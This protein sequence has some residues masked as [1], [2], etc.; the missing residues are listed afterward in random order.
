MEI[1]GVLMK[2]RA[3]VEK[4]TAEIAALE[5]EEI[6]DME[7]YLESKKLRLDMDI[8][9]MY[10]IRDEEDVDCEW[11]KIHPYYEW[12]E[13]PIGKWV[14]APPLPAPKKAVVEEQPLPPPKTPERN[15]A[16]RGPPGAPKKNGEKRLYVRDKAPF[17]VED[18]NKAR[19]IMMVH[20][21]DPNDP[22]L[23]SDDAKGR[24]VAA[25]QKMYRRRQTFKERLDEVDDTSSKRRRAMSDEG[26]NNNDPRNS[27][28][29]PK[30]AMN[31]MKEMERSKSES[32]KAE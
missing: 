28:K 27:R 1:Q 31:L 25:A 21:D 19:H 9:E 17:T 6:Q 4:Y 7:A 14:F 8:H 30:T 13:K 11:Y 20:A 10:E 24:A 26:H 23:D 5:K 22:W 32:E 29:K 18:L 2:K 12:D 3:E 16:V 15:G